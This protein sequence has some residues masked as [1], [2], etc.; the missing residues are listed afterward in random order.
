MSLIIDNGYHY[1]LDGTQDVISGMLDC[2][3]CQL[4]FF[5]KEGLVNSDFTP[6]SLFSQDFNISCVVDSDGKI[7]HIGT[8]ESILNVLKITKE[9][10][11]HS[12][13][14]IT[15]RKVEG[16][17]GLKEV[18]SLLDK[19]EKVII[20]TQANRVPYFISFK[21]F[22][23]KLDTDSAGHAFLAVGHKGDDLY[24]V[25]FPYFASNAFVEHEDYPD[26]GIASKKS[27]EAAF[28][29]FITYTTV[30][31]KQDSIKSYCSKENFIRRLQST[32]NKFNSPDLK[33]D[34][35]TL[36]TGQSAYVA[37]IDSLNSKKIDL[38]SE[39]LYFDYY[40]V[41]NFITV[42]D[43]QL[44]ELAN[45]RKVLLGALTQVPEVDLGDSIVEL[46]D[47]SVS[48]WSH[49]S[50]LS[51]VDP[52]TSNTDMVYDKLI[53]YFKLAYQTDLELYR[54][55]HSSFNIDGAV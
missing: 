42:L 11:L 35:Y 24:Y 22:K 26:I 55:L 17:A 45:R 20:Q 39:D 40:K 6:F 19:G 36:K 53:T 2:F 37:I 34:N 33:R 48:L 12:L 46:F 5:V 52:S 38:F 54:R 18:E 3:K 25:D 10:N 32:H 9:D 51:C 29:S 50:S 49:L 13:F 28:S 30:D 23:A 31:F 7:L 21:D 1:N 41:K 47:Y 15:T 16:S 14:D 8:F 4:Y 43:W 44:F 27:L